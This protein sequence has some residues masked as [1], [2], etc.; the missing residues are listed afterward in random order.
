MKALTRRA[1]PFALA[2]FPILLVLTACHGGGGGGGNPCD[3]YAVAGPIE[4]EFLETVTFSVT[5]NGTPVPGTTWRVF[6]NTNQQVDQ[7]VLS[8]Q[9][10]GFTWTAPAP[11]PALI[12]T[13]ALEVEVPNSDCNGLR[14]EFQLVALSGDLLELQ[15]N[16]VGAIQEIRGP[17]QL[18]PGQPLQATLFRNGVPDTAGGTQFVF[19]DPNA[20]MYLRETLQNQAS[21]LFTPDPRV[22]GTWTLSVTT[23]TNE[24][25]QTSF[26]TVGSSIDLRANEVSSGLFRPW[27]FQFTGRDFGLVTQNGTPIPSPQPPAD[28]NTVRMFKPGGGLEIELNIQGGETVRFYT[29]DIQSGTGIFSA[30]GVD[31]NGNATPIREFP[32]MT[33][34]DVSC[35]FGTFRLVLGQ[36]YDISIGTTLQFSSGRVEF[37]FLDTMTP[38][39]NMSVS[40]GPNQLSFSQWQANLPTAGKY[41]AIVVL[42]NQTVGLA[43]TFWFESAN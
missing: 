33:P 38:V 32:V 27:M 41:A 20:R 29:T 21:V 40:L 16:W 15:L 39:P 5:G 23:A 37:V 25:R 14:Y 2:L 18:V 3:S 8:P 6:D 1:I 31:T 34:N 28:P 42:D 11:D 13:W 19:T 24:M 35:D 36:R 30:F 22:L 10:T 43:S 7:Q 17:Q 4:V 26:F 9:I 12:G